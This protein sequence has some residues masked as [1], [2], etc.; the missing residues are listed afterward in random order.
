MPRG[1]DI[2]E[3][4]LVDLGEEHANEVFRD[5]SGGEEEDELAVIESVFALLQ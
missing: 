2:L 4:V 5:A 1:C 3:V